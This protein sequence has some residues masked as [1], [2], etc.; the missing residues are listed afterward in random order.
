MLCVEVYQWQLHVIFVTVIFVIIN[1]C[2]TVSTVIIVYAITIL[3]SILLS[4]IITDCI[5]YNVKDAEM[6]PNEN[7][8]YK[9]SI[10]GDYVVLGS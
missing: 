7:E 10:N 8:Q 9:L 5:I 4:N 6:I 1:Y 2:N 3:L